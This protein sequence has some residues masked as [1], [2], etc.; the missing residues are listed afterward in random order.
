MKSFWLGVLANFIFC[1]LLLGG[2]IIYKQ[3]EELKK[4]D[5]LDV[6]FDCNEKNVGAIH[7]TPNGTA[8]MC[9]EAPSK[10]IWLISLLGRCEK[11]RY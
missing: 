2:L 11:G 10:Y 9:D 8:F 5:Y 7:C 3:S 4:W 1:S 6:N